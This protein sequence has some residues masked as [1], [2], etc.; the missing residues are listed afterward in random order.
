MKLQLLEEISKANHELIIDWDR[1]LLCS[2]IEKAIVIL[3]KTIAFKFI[4]RDVINM[5]IEKNKRKN[6]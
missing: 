2:A 4:T 3:D 1:D 6:K 5:K